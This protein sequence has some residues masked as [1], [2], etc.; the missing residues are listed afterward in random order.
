[1]WFA[2]WPLSTLLAIGGTA[3]ALTVA[4]YFLKLRRRPVVVPFLSMW[5]RLL[6]DQEASRL[7][8]ELRRWLSLL[9]HLALVA[10]IVLALGDPRVSERWLNGRHLVVLVDT[11]ASMQAT[12]PVSGATRLDDARQE[13]RRLVDGLSGAD[14]LLIAQL[15]EGALPLS[16]M[17]DD[18]AELADA[19]ERVAATAT[20]TQLEAGL[21]FA[22]D[23]LRG[24][25]NPE[26][27]LI[28]DGAFRDEVEDVSRRL[29]LGDVPLRYI[30]VGTASPN[31]A[32]T[33]FAARRY[34]LDRS[35]C[36]VLLEVANLSDAVKTVQVTIL[37]DGQV[38]DVSE[39][40]LQPRETLP[41][42]YQDL[43]G[44][45]ET[46]EAQI[47]TPDG[48]DALTLDNQ[49]FALLPER[50]RSKV[51]VVTP[52]NTYLEAA[53]LLDE[54][55]EVT[56]VAPSDPLPSGP[57]D[58]TIQDGVNVE[59]PPDFGSLIYLNPP[60]EGGP[61]AHQRSLDDFGFDTWDKK[62]PLLAFIAPENIQVLKGVS[63][64]PQSGDKVVGASSQ[65]PF[66]VTGTRDSRKFVA[67][68][69]DPR[70]SDMVLRI[71]WPL[72]ILNSIQYATDRDG[73]DFLAY[74]T[75]NTW[76]LPVPNTHSDVTLVGPDDLVRPLVV[77]G[78]VASFFGE[79]PGFY[80][81]RVNQ[82]VVTK[83]AA[84]FVDARESAL[85]VR[86]ELTYGEATATAPI[87][88]SAGLRRELWGTLLLIVIALSVVE[89]FTF[90]RR[91][92]V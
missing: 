78:G 39:F 90:Q 65:G 16:T 19:V 53:L 63:F 72:F 1:M 73:D 37:G 88:F 76:R 12:D 9:L 52:G 22:L 69:F 43:G 35:R 44:G 85:D 13:L 31:V 8:A 42:F 30:A 45:N 57:F 21:Q 84:N 51:L 87:G 81:L 54:Y 47:A 75:G 60:A 3:A 50:R 18:T 11:S 68:G 46:L 10:L 24:R 6:R 89:W 62:S 15:G 28:S 14:R 36:E 55:L 20:G 32:I 71:A 77:R 17:T 27:I 25:K 66:L 5:E 4:L 41:R 58:V 64:K 38:I 91:V 23:T 70:V 33:S 83:F 49:A 7:F 34:P 67:L 80:E 82:D 92:T 26:I 40:Q 61:L 48:S 86:T 2:G 79:R 56:T 74:R 59:T 29:P